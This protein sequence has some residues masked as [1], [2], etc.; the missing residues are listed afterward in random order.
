MGYPKLRQKQC[1]DEEEIN[2]LEALYTMYRIRS[3]NK[4]IRYN[5]GVTQGSIL[6]P[7]LFDIFIEDL[8]L[9]I[10]QSTNMSLEDILLYADDILLL[11]DSQ[12]QI[13]RCIEIIAE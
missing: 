6:S 1:L 9:A 8:V 12:S 2:Y 4:I 5:K 7:A 13:S 10:N 11:D 3:G